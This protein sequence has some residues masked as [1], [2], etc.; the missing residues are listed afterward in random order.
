MKFFIGLLSL[1]FFNLRSFA[2]E[3]AMDIFKI[4]RIA[5]INIFGLDISFNNISLSLFLTFAIFS[6]WFF[7]I[8]KKTLLKNVNSIIA[9]FIYDLML[10]IIEDE[11]EVRRYFGLIFSVFI[12]VLISNLIG[13]FIPFAITSTS[14][15]GVVFVI[16]SLVFLT[17]IIVMFKH[18][19]LHSYKMFIPQGVP[20]ALAPL[21]FI[22]EFF[23]YIAKP[24]TLTIRL[25]ANMIAGHLVMHIVSGFVITMKLFGFIPFAFLVVLFGFE[26]FVCILQ[27]YIF[28]LLSVIYV[29]Q[30]IK[31]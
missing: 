15:V 27:S 3:S 19:G 17:T 7:I 21:V 30:A 14:H 12:F 2:E 10:N 24:I 29:S 23:G 31:H 1:F 20:I 25:V 8:R 22:L 16:A 5:P 6:L 13:L 11:K 9:N 4:K 28:A 18:H 26:F